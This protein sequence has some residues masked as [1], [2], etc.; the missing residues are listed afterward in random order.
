MQAMPRE[1]TIIQVKAAALA[2][3][4]LMLIFRRFRDVEFHEVMTQERNT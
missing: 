2:V 3:V 1:I 4:A